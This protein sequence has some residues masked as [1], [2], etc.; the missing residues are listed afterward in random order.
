MS[1]RRVECFR[2]S[3]RVRLDGFGAGIGTG[4]GGGDRGWMLG[5]G[6]GSILVIR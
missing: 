6:L 4:F 5:S 2:V 3:F 1:V